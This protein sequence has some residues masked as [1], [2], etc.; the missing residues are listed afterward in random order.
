MESK[1]T[2]KAQGPQAE[3]KPKGEE[4]K[5]Q[6]YSVNVDNVVMATGFAPNNQLKEMFI[7]TCDEVYVV[8]DCKMPRLIF[9]AI[10]EGHIAA[11][12]I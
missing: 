10:H 11:R 8:G 2:Q 5:V 6:R 3:G 12:W 1:R 4:E 7:E 9:D